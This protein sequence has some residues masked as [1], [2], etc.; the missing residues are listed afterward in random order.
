MGW[1]FWKREPNPM[2]P[3]QLLTSRIT[4]VEAFRK[5]LTEAHAGDNVGLLLEGV[6]KKD[7]LSG[8]VISR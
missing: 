7:L 6:T 4:G 3:Q 2:D 5:K 1:K 8:D